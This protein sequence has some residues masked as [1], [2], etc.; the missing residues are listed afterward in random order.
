MMKKRKRK[1]KRKKR[2]KWWRSFLQIF[3]GD[4]QRCLNETISL[5]VLGDVIDL[6]SPKEKKEMKWKRK[7]KKDGEG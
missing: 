5:D 4:L 1:R 2:K 3:S 7:W 6:W